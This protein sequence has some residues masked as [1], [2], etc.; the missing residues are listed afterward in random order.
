MSLCTTHLMEKVDIRPKGVGH[1][2]ET[3]GVC[4]ADELTFGWRIGR[5][6]NDTHLPWGHNVW[7]TQKTH[8]TRT[9]TSKLARHTLAEPTKRHWLVAFVPAYAAISASRF[10][11]AG[12]RSGSPMEVGMPTATQDAT[13]MHSCMRRHDGNVACI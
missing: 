7:D 3:S 1:N 13:S 5:I 11:S 4:L 8:K 9:L 10:F 6:R 2:G 12:P